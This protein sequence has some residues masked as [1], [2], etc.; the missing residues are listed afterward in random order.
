MFVNAT[1]RFKNKACNQIGQISAGHMLCLSKI[2]NSYQIRKTL[3][4]ILRAGTSA[5]DRYISNI[6]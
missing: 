5:E 2:L 1:A 4:L 3:D 6:V